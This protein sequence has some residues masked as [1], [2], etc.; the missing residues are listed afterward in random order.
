M[1]HTQTRRSFSPVRRTFGPVSYAA[2]AL[3]WSAAA[4]AQTQPNINAVNLLSPFNTLLSFPNVMTS[5]LNTAISINNSS[6]AA[7]RTQA[8][9]DNLI[10]TDNG[11]V[12]ADGLGSALNKV[13][14]TAITA[15]NPLLSANGNIVQAFRQGNGISQADSG[16]AKYWF[17]N[18]TTDGTTPSTLVNPRPNIYDRAYGITPF[19]LDRFGD[20]RPFQVAPNQIQNFAPTI[21]S[22]L[23]NNPAFPSGHTTFGYTQS[24]LQAIMVPEAY[25][26]QLT[27]ASEYGNSR[28]VLGPHYPLDV[29]GGRILAT[30]D[31]V[32]LLNNNP[33][34]LNQSINVFAV[35]QV[36]TTGDYAGL[37]AAA[38]A[39]YRALLTQG[40]GTS[41]AACIAAGDPDR[42][43][44]AA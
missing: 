7:Q 16:F 41:I 38:T 8:V 2:M 19:S 42:F 26:T 1:K 25:Q 31:V 15:N 9:T 43:S 4:Q 30:Y 28:I 13:V 22:G 35:G 10:T 14:Q 20:S 39:D 24:L 3:V 29:I 40:C 5:T 34:Y 18:S 33:Q 11:Q 37:F 12:L 36:T 21:T 23:T 44:N 6:T 17:A 32:Q 27:R